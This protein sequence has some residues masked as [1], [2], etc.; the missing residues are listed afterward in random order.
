M[1]MT[2]DSSLSKNPGPQ[3]ALE[4]PESGSLFPCPTLAMANFRNK[5]IATASITSSNVLVPSSDG[6]QPNSF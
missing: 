5:G 4:G 3:N 2:P 1:E 6:L